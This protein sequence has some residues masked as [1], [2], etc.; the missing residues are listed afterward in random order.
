MLICLIFDLKFKKKHL[1]FERKVFP[2]LHKSA[3]P[4]R[5]FF[6]FVKTPFFKYNKHVSLGA[7]NI[8]QQNTLRPRARRIGG[9][10]VLCI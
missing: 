1:N 5:V 8:G 2:D 3:V 6:V 4:D 10:C 7:K 9:V